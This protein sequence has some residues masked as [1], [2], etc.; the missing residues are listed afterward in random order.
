[1]ISTLSQKIRKI[2]TELSNRMT[3]SGQEGQ[4]GEMNEVAQIYVPG[5]AKDT[6]KA[7]TRYW[8]R[9]AVSEPD[10]VMEAQ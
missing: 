7:R 4:P 6:I 8:R 10:P 9:P 3:L 1:M 2:G 5:V